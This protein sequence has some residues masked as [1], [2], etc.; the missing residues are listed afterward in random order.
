MG[1]VDTVG[2]CEQIDEQIELPDRVVKQRLA[3]SQPI[4]RRRL[5]DQLPFQI[6]GN[7]SDDQSIEDRLYILPRFRNVCKAL[8]STI[9]MVTGFDE[10]PF[11]SAKSRSP[12]AEQPTPSVELTRAV[13][14]PLSAV[15][16]RLSSIGGEKSILE[17]PSTF[18]VD[19]S[20]ASMGADLPPS[21]PG[22]FDDQPY[23][24]PVVMSPKAPVSASKDKIAKVLQSP[25][26][27]TP[28]SKK[29][30][31]ASVASPEHRM[32][33]RTKNV[34]G[35]LKSRFEENAAKG[36]KATVDFEDLCSGASRKSAAG[37]FLECL[38]LKTWGLVDMKQSSAYANLSLSPVAVA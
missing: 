21:S 22:Y 32:S 33:D 3:D 30:P 24:E 26:T 5:G 11:S 38:Q 1:C 6:G 9:D 37:F 34:L 35:L 18:D 7:A 19:V 25:A 27:A 36:K 17:E 28:G 16:R 12:A 8:Q 20:F 2:C 4:L 13:G 23:I 15:D 29:S 10:F 14:E 31:L